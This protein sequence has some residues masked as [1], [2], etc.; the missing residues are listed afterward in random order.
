[1]KGHANAINDKNKGKG[2]LYSDDLPF[3]LSIAINYGQRLYRMYIIK[4]KTSLM[5]GKREI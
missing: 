3:I 1:M 4:L 5:E 2:K